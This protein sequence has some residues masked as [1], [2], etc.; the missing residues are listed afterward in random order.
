MGKTFSQASADLAATPGYPAWTPT[1]AGAHYPCIAKGLDITTPPVITSYLHAGAA[2]IS[3][4]DNFSCDFSAI[5]DGAPI[6]RSQ[7]SIYASHDWGTDYVRIWGTLAA[8]PAVLWNT[9]AITPAVLA[10]WIS[11]AE[12]TPGSGMSAGIVGSDLKPTASLVLNGESSVGITVYA[13]VAEIVWGGGDRIVAVHQPTGIS[14]LVANKGAGVLDY[15]RN[16]VQTIAGVTPAA[17]TA[18]AAD[19]PAGIATIGGRVLTYFERSGAS[20]CAT[21]QR[22]GTIWNGGD[23]AAVSAWATYVVKHVTQQGRTQYAVLYKSGSIYFSR[24]TAGDATSWSAPALIV[25]SLADE[26]AACIVAQA[27]G[28]LLAYYQLGTSTP[29]VL[30]CSKQTGVG[31]A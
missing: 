15:R 26:P 27:D 16:R 9:S 20:Y 25:G 8:D 4:I 18:N 14:H 3:H 21:S 31:W 1:P 30:A 13:V 5:P 19:I 24:N 17:A 6:L 12:C 10:G 29:V 22:D 11:A 23:M 7:V 2:G 28:R